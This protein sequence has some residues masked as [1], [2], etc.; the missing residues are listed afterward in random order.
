MEKVFDRLEDW[1]LAWSWV[2]IETLKLGSYQ[3]N[4]IDSSCK[5]DGVCF[6]GS[7][8]LWG[9]TQSDE[10]CEWFIECGLQFSDTKF[11]WVF[12]VLDAQRR[13]VFNDFEIVDARVFG[14]K[15]L[16]ETFKAWCGPGLARLAE[17]LSADSQL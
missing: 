14:G 11:R 10:D 15:D 9:D 8:G 13:E 5:V 16:R 7:I 2:L 6:L 17:L 12:T 3:A 4:Q 1:S